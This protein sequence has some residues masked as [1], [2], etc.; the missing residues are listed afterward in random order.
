MVNISK[1]CFDALFSPTREMTARAS[2]SPASGS[3]ISLAAAD[4][5]QGGIRLSEAT[6]TSGSFDLGAAVISKLTLT[7]NNSDGR[8]NGVNFIGGQVSSIQI[9]V[10][11]PNNATEWIPLGMFDIDSVKYSGTAAEIVAYDYLSRADKALPAVSCPVTLGNLVRTVCTHCGVIWSGQSFLNDDYQVEKLPDHATCR[12]VISYAAALAG[13]YARMS[14]EGKLTFG[15]YGGNMPLW[16]AEEWL[17]GG[18]FLDMTS[19][20]SADGGDFLDYN[21]ENMDGGR[22]DFRGFCVVNNPKSITGVKPVTVAGILFRSPDEQR[23]ALD[24][25][26]NEIMETVPGTAY[27]SGTDD[28][29]FD[30]SENPLLT[31]DIPA[32][33]AALGQKLIG[34]SFNPLS[35]SCPSNPAFEAGDIVTVADR[36]GNSFRAYINRCEYKFGSPQ[37][38]ICEAQTPAEN[39]A[40]KYSYVSRLEQKIKSE[41]DKKISAYSSRLQALNN[42]MLNSMGVYK[43]SVQNADGSVT[44][45]TH[46]KP[47]LAASSYIACETSNG[48]AYTNSGWNDGSPVWQYGM[49]ADGNIICN[50]L[51]AVGIIA[52]WI[53]AGRIESAD[54]SCYFDLDNN[55]LF[56]NKIGLSTRYLSAGEVST[57]TGESRAGIACYDSELSS[58]PYIQI[59]PVQAQSDAALM[60]YGLADQLGRIQLLCAA[61]ADQLQ[62]NA[63]AIYGYDS[64]GDRHEML[65]ISAANGGIKLTSM[66]GQ[67]R[68]QI[69]N[70]GISV[71][72]NNTLVQSW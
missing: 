32:V 58:H 1:A 34:E 2:I 59:R 6:S 53:Q 19:G 13:C 14:R 25:D 54:G 48:F 41:T 12:D 40:E 50:V 11:L 18:I 65:V 37:S 23:T 44:T 33:L 57:D 30:L 5:K 69:T 45:Y 9:G 66:N 29:C 63:V 62:N 28:Y 43:T 61:R 51:S 68:I 60:G 20:D 27:I 38:L 4:F 26:G 55:Q 22:N 72:K 49:T 67:N 39:A 31:H 17:D 42:L 64:S 56:A 35:L 15:W 10:T 70:N 46:D 21:D 52:D 24:E 36:R 16:G 3:V 8:F 7:L 47:T 71:Y